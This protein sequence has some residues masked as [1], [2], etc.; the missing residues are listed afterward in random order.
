M[1]V[2]CLCV[3]GV[4]HIAMMVP[5]VQELQR[6][7][8]EVRMATGPDFCPQIE[9]SGVVAVPAG[10]TRAVARAERLRRH[11]DSVDV[12]PEE[13]QAFHVPKVWGG[14]YAP[15][16][17][18]DLAPVVEEWRPDLL[19]YDVASFSGPL[20]AEL[21]E[22]PGVSH[23]FGPSFPAAVLTSAEAELS[24]LWNAHGR[25]VPPGGGMLDSPHIDVWPASLQLPDG[26]RPKAVTP[27]RV[28]GTGRPAGLY[29]TEVPASLTTLPHPVVHVTLGT[30]FNHDTPLFALVI[31]ALRDEGLS[32]VVTT[33]PDQDP[34]VL[35]AQPPSVRVERFLPHHALLPYCDL[36]VSH[37]G[38]GTTLAALGHGIPSLL[39]P[40]AAD[41]FRA[42]E[43][44]VR[45]GAGLRL[46][47]AEV[48]EDA[49]R[50]SV[51]ELID[52]PGYRHKAGKLR[53]EIARMPEP[54]DV[55]ERLEALARG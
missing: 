31:E 53:A 23:A 52:D 11:P 44:C 7:G 28:T 34:S 17:F 18:A 41:G 24:P 51:R 1:K 30:V 22:I 32:L 40:Q 25:P 2:L 26:F 4:G 36:V 47:P 33:G 49:V 50:R 13:Q 8:H 19:V 45:A 9:S 21:A 12:S 48:T 6:A 20:L 14:I 42:A 16:T 37:S 29:A 10:P 3:P 35:G 15:A 5:V 38:A 54:A 39:L 27:V 46:T 55:V 43:G